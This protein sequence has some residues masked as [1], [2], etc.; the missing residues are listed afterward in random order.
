MSDQPDLVTTAIAE[1]VTAV[2]DVRLTQFVSF[3]CLEHEVELIW[4]KRWSVIKLAFL[5]HRYFGIICVLWVVPSLHG[6]V[7]QAEPP[8]EFWFYWETWGYSAVLFTSEAVLLLWIYVVYNKNRWVLALMSICYLCEVAAVVA[9]L[10]ISF[11]TFEARAHGIPGVEYC[12][13]TKIGP[14]FPLL[15]VPILAYDALLLLL[16]LYRGCAGASPNSSWRWAYS[17][18]GLL[19]MIYRYSL[20]NFLAIFASYLACAIIWLTCD[21]G[22]YQIPVG[23]A[24]SLSITNCTRLLL[25]IRHAYYTGVRDPLLLNVRDIPATGN[26]T[27]TPDSILDTPLPPHTPGAFSSCSAAS[28]YSDSAFSGPTLRNPSVTP[29]SSPR[30]DTA[31]PTSTVRVT[32]GHDHA[33]EV[34]VSRPGTSGSTRGI[35]RL[36]GTPRRAHEYVR[37]PSVHLTGVMNPEWWQYEMREIRA[38]LRISYGEAV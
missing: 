4:K 26:N 19:D 15:W 6:V 22:L 17:Y 28:A 18:D 8:C 12:V 14:P 29:T 30:C 1:F 5:W 16:F 13:M 34:A 25:N 3:I 32:I 35:Q 20:L 38:D 21:L 7:W 31:S 36:A 24:L 23:F 9:I 11:E 37:E 33:V 10:T 27:P 2:R